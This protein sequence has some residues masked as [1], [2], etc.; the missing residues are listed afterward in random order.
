MYSETKERFYQ[1]LTWKNDSLLNITQ[2]IYVNIIIS[3]ITRNSK[4]SWVPW[5]TVHGRCLFFIT[6]YK[7]L[8]WD[9]ILRGEYTLLHFA[10]LALLKWSS[11]NSNRW[12][13]DM[14]LGVH[15]WTTKLRL[16]RRTSTLYI[17][18][19]VHTLFI[20][21]PQDWQTHKHILIRCFWCYSTFTVNLI[22]K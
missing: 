4:S 21:K 6:T 13:S 20:V 7:S 10:S 15:Q 11:I 22:H 3:K 5:C 18:V 2:S 12:G 16:M 19:M 14:I 17:V 8:N 1:V 9:L